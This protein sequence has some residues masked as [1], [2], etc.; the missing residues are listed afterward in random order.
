MKFFTVNFIVCFDSIADAWD[1]AVVNI[2]SVQA[3]HVMPYHSGWTYQA[4]KAAVTTMTKCMA[5]DLSAHGIRVNSICPGYIWTE[6]VI[7]HLLLVILLN[8]D[9]GLPSSHSVVPLFVLSFLSWLV[10]SFLVCSLFVNSLSSGK[11][12]SFV[13]TFIKINY[14]VS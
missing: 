4:S 8:C 1:C 12:M 3:H 2:S 14:K 10:L 13:R 11:L 5:L 6:H 7:L 9:R